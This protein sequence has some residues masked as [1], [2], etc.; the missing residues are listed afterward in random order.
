MKVEVEIAAAVLGALAMLVSLALTRR[1]KGN[2]W[3]G[4]FAGFGTA[5]FVLVFAAALFNLLTN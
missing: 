3:A 2:G 5:S 1:N 4:W